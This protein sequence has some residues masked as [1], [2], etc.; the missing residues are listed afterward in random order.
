MI[1][2][3]FR[4]DLEIFRRAPSHFWPTPQNYNRELKQR[5]RRRRRRQR[6]RQKSNRV[7]L[8]D[9]QLCTFFCTF[10]SLRCTTKRELTSYNWT[11]SRGREQKTTTFFLLL[12]S[13]TSPLEFN[14]K[15]ICQHS[16]NKTSSR[17]SE[18]T[19]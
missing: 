19:F 13:D 17:Q 18:F 10:P 12:I 7:R 6:G 15:K 11:F 9:K 2:V 5:R 1:L 16:T 3:S 14:S 8:A 4:G